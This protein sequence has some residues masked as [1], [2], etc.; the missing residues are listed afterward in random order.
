M[1]DEQAVPP[2]P[3]ARRRPRTA[4]LIS[5]GIGAVMLLLVAVLATREPAVSRLA[6]SPL[7]GRLAPEL[8]ST[9]IAGSRRY[10][11]DDRRGE[12]VVVNFFATWCVPCIE[13]H[14]DLVRFS[15]A[16]AAKGDASVVSV[17]FSDDLGSA[18]GFFERRGGTWPVLRDESADI[19]IDWGVARVP[20]SYLVA[21]SGIVVGK[22]TG[23][24]TFEFLEEQLSQL[25]GTG[26]GRR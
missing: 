11:L 12:F 17:V 16:H 25:T 14:D 24:V 23:G 26:T 13:E 19:A 5:A 22:I 20:E 8:E 2:E 10:S 21:P 4:L 15:E 18:R 9:T 1:S 3:V 7:V 6:R